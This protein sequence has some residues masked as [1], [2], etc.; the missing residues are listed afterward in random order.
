MS[1]LLTEDANQ[2]RGKNYGKDPL[3]AYKATSDPDTLYHHQAMKVNDRKAILFAMIKEVT[4]Q[5]N[6]ENFLLIRREEI[7]EGSTLLPGA[8]QM[9]RNRNIKTLQIKRWKSRLNVDGSRMKKE[10][11][12][13]KVYSQVEG[14]PSIRI[15]LILVALEQCKTMRVDYVQAFLQSPIEKDL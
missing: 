15:I 2:E 10:I 13:Y 6:N 12:Y 14:C 1:A 11:Q 5:I 3:P 9:K 8:W 4:D 7:L